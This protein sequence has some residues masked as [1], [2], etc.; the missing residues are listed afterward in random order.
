MV[1]IAFFCVAAV[2]MEAQAFKLPDYDSC[3]QQKDTCAPP[4]LTVIDHLERFALRG[5]LLSKLL[6]SVMVFENKHP[7]KDTTKVSEQKYI[8]SN[9]K[10]IRQIQIIV[11]GPFGYS[12]TDQYGHRINGLERLGDNVHYNSRNWVVADKLLFKAGQKIDPLKI[13]E[14]ER[15]IRQSPYIVDAR[16][17]LRPIPNSTDSMDVWVIAQDVFNLGASLSGDPSKPNGNLEVTDN[18]FLGLG[19]KM[20][21]SIWFD[22]QYSQHFKYSGSYSVP[23]IA[24]TYISSEVHYNT[25][26]YDRTIGF[27]FNRPF[28]SSTTKW[29]GGLDVEFIH[30]AY[31]VALP[32]SNSYAGMHDYNT[33]DF[34]LGYAFN[35]NETSPLKKSQIVVSGRVYSINYDYQSVFP[36]DLN[37][38]FQ[39]DLLCLAGI[40]FD[41]R[42]YYK[43]HYIFA[44]GKT[45]DIPLGYLFS[46]NTGPDRSQFYSRWYTGAKVSYGWNN[47][48]LGYMY[49]SVESGGFIH[50][51]NIE[52]GVI[53]TEL[54]Y[55]TNLLPVGPW[56][57]RQYLMNRFTLGYNRRPG[58]LISINGQYG[59]SKFNAPNLTGTQR[60][61]NNY[62]ADLFTTFNPFGFRIVLV[63]YLDDA[64]IGDHNKTVLQ[65]RLYE[66]YGIAVRFKNEHFTFNTLELGF[67][68]FPEGVYVGGNAYNFSSSAGS[69]FQFQDFSFTEPY[70]AGFK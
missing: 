17:S 37:H 42:E 26:N 7:P 70:T 45:E 24:K 1:I 65:S 30:Q 47:S 35:I 9:Q 43:D 36:D 60:W 21:N 39:N 64:L 19:Q 11:L 2:K 20:D 44:F 29:A 8:G 66:G 32:D 4:K 10:Y 33:K 14:S 50:Q 3:K 25:V 51:N 61:V 59:L 54:F 31:N 52:Q 55:F 27:S 41:H 67:H 63:F 13:A 69:N 12:V 5:N 68:Y 56:Q 62:E 16:I 53:N 49:L 6:R 57:W 18:N 46:F 23:Q 15:L 34:W 40:G 38:N 58:E 48:S 28:Y 22:R